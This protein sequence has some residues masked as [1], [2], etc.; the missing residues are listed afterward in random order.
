MR[1]F[2]KINI[3]SFLYLQAC[4]STSGYITNDYQDQISFLSTRLA[5]DPNVSSLLKQAAI[6]SLSCEVVPGNEGTYS[7]WVYLSRSY[8][9]IAESNLEILLQ[10]RSTSETLFAVMF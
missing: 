8:F 2:S 3:D 1:F 4:E 5:I 10:V 9:K 7:I 6:R